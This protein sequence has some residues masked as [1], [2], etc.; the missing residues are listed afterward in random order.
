MLRIELSIEWYAICFD[1]G[2]SLENAPR[3]DFSDKTKYAPTDSIKD[4]L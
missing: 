4:R 3:Y 1:D 2:F